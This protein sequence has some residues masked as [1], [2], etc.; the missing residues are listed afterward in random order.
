MPY[1]VKADLRTEIYVENM[2]EIIREDSAIVID[3]INSAIDEAK[4][5]LQRFDLLK[6]F[7]TDV[8]APTYVNAALKKKIKFI[9]VW[10]L[11]SLAN[12]NVKIELARTNYEDTIRWL[13]KISKREINPGFPLPTDDEDTTDTDESNSV[14]WDSEVKRKNH[15]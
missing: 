4:S 15:Y 6:I 2:D 5:Y 12:P 8:V 1:L 13:E 11:V 14:E 10:W 3:A 7:G 9:A